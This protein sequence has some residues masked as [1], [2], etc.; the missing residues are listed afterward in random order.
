MADIG[1]RSIKLF[2][3]LAIVG[4]V[5]CGG[6]GVDTSL[7]TPSFEGRII[8]DA[9]E[10]PWSAL[11]RVNTG[12]QGH[13]TGVLVSKS[14]VLTEA[15]CLYNA[16][17]GRWWAPSELHFIAGYQRDSYRIHSAVR[18][19][20]VAPGHEGG[21][22][23][24][25]NIMNNWAVL[26][27]DR[28]V[29][30]QAGWLALQWPDRH[31]LARLER[32]DAYILDAGYRAGQSHVITLMPDCTLDSLSRRELK[33]WS[34]CRWFVAEAGLSKLVFINGE[35]RVL[36]PRQLPRSVAGFD[37]RAT[38][39]PARGSGL[40]SL[41]SRQPEPAIRDLLRRLGYRNGVAI[42]SGELLQGSGSTTPHGTLVHLGSLRS[43]A[44][45]RQ[46]WKNLKKAFPSELVELDL[47]V[48]RVDLETKGVFYRVLADTSLGPNSAQQLCSKLR[49]NDQYCSIKSSPVACSGCA[50]GERSRDPGSTTPRGTL[51]HLSSLRSEASARQEWE[52]LKKTFPSELA[53]LDLTVQRVDIETKGVFYRVLTDT[54]LDPS[55]A[56]QFCGTLRQNDQYCSIVKPGSVSDQS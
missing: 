29:G 40:K 52:N 50:G 18:R 34:A 26:L 15:R 45:A 56:Q 3:L 47:T 27:L 11:G 48:K 31:M 23:T 8:V 43:E 32:G 4:L 5:P 9:M 24:L 21:A 10:Y 12:G 7:A 49:E 35:F 46:E 39:A 19:Y 30:L 55:R 37:L 28:P 54:N 33:R 6:F 13:C 17:E 14:H 2:G 22:G 20:H 41:T 44:S 1:F 25:A 53:E 42:A 36:A 38:Q 16:T 51:V